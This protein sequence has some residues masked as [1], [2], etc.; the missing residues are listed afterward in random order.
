MR[1]PGCEPAG[2]SSTPVRFMRS[3]KG[4]GGLLPLPGRAAPSR[5]PGKQEKQ[6]AW[7]CLIS[8]LQA[9]W[10]LFSSPFLV[11]QPSLPLVS[12]LME[13][14]VTPSTPQNESVPCCRGERR[15]SCPGA[16]GAR[17]LQLCTAQGGLP[18]RPSC[19]QRCRGWKCCLARPGALRVF[20]H[21]LSD[22]K[23]SI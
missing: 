8:S 1:S 2:T 18:H 7:C 9:H 11:Y 14:V 19:R 3:P 22:S 15:P 4:E 16:L 17:H 21:G 12:R 5:Q 20:F 6:G 13:T 23:Q 10:L